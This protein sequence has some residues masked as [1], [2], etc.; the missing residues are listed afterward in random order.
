MALGAGMNVNASSDTAEDNWLV[1]EDAPEQATA[2]VRGNPWRILIVDDDKDVHLMTQF[3]LLNVV[4]MDRTL[5]LLSAYSGREAFQKLREETD[6][7]LVLLDVVMETPDAG[8]RLAKQIREEL[9]NQ[10]VRVVLRTGQPGQ[11]PEQRVIVDYDINDYKGKAELTKQKLFTT[12][13]ASLRAYD[14]LLTIERSK[15]ELLAFTAENND[16]KLALDQH[17][18]VSITD[19]M[20]KLIYAN[21]KFCNI[22]G[23]PRE[24]LIGKNHAI[25]NSHHHPRSFFSEMWQTIS[26]GNVWQ[27]E[28][29]NR[30]Q[31]GSNFWV[32]ST[33]VPFLNNEGKPYQYVAI[34]TNITERKLAE[35]A[36][37]SN[38]ARLRRMLEVSPIAV[39]IKRLSNN[40][41]VFANKCLLD[42]FDV[43]REAAQGADPIHY[44]QNPE[45]YR[46][47]SARLEQGETIVNREIGL[48]KL[49][50]SQIRVL[51]S[52]FHMEYEGEP[53]VMGWFFEITEILH[54]RELAEAA[55]RAKSSFL[56]TM[57]HEIRTPMNGIIGMSDLLIETELTAQQGEFAH[58]IRD[59]A[60]SLMAIV[61]DILDFSKI[62]A[63]K[64]AL[65]TI[66]FSL[67]NVIESSVELLAP[68]AREKGLVVIQYIAPEIPPRLM[69]DPGRLRQILINLISNAI[70]FTAHGEVQITCRLLQQNDGQYKMRFEVQDNGIGMSEDV[71]N[72][73]FQP[74]TQADGSFTRKY[75]GTG[76]GLSI[77]KRLVE[78]MNGQIG[79]DSREGSGSRFWFEL[80][81][82][83]GKAQAVTIDTSALKQRQIWLVMPPSTLRDVM[84]T[85]LQEQD[86]T[87]R[88]IDN[89]V[90]S[91]QQPDAVDLI[92]VS[93]TV[94][95]MPIAAAMAALK[96]IHPA[97]GMVLLAKPGESRPATP[98]VGAYHCL[99]QPVK[100]GQLYDTLLR[101]LTPVTASA[102]TTTPTSTP[103]PPAPP[104]AKL[105][106]LPTTSSQI[107][108]TI[109]IL[110][111]D[112]NAVN[113][114]LAKALLN[115][116][117]YRDID[118]ADNGQIAVEAVANK[119]YHLVLMDCQ[120]PLMDGFVATR[121]IRAA[122]QTGTHHV[123]IIAMTANAIQGDRE[124]CLQAGMDDYLAK[125][126][127]PKALQDMLTRWLP[128]S[129]SPSQLA[130]ETLHGAALAK[131]LNRDR[132]EEICGGDQV[133]YQGILEVFIEHT[134][135]LLDRIHQAILQ[136]NGSELKSACHE[137][138]GSASN[139]GAD[140][141]HLLAR[142]LE[143]SANLQDT[144]LALSLHAALG[145][146]LEN[147][148]DA[149]R[150]RQGGK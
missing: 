15:E 107:Q 18:S 84:Q 145:Q 63:G 92:L 123:P 11:A 76:L 10:L 8:L 88:T 144:T 7:A 126:I 71:T 118:T 62:E 150:P 72:R 29:Q 115:K 3:A 42:M 26:Q 128:E 138:A 99:Y 54:A 96:G 124:Q 86:C 142:K 74:F 122:E 121:L 36:L 22:S 14:N 114:K 127:G 80:T 47:I 125:P 48:I 81:M 41:R 110:L 87:V 93:A 117:G 30:A 45:E 28:I 112:D 68:K 64:L 133:V 120:M 147:L 89:V 102:P 100:P 103:A 146:A 60:Q 113:Q 140:Q 35:Q 149:I 39:S 129:A 83:S 97:S 2:A 131:I 73:L 12:V 137:L 85:Q 25:L 104:V 57:S 55:S 98:V 53:A 77:C 21:D 51:A 4:F 50:H 27:G 94:S 66:D 32:D 31:D 61:N 143:H 49:D 119:S 75:G 139:M 6:I 67:P 23:Y 58:I 132:I 16:L 136:H 130:K 17:A 101:A 44:Y 43:S 24:E 40:Q 9:N 141:L 135:S 82:S 19:Q 65:E 105:A 108:T 116:L 109:P 1:D 46:E 5:E 95:D 79:V 148:R 59:C 111:V 13:I 69:G 34:D 91:L 90:T 70:K 38:A 78:L 52:Y 20:G 134:P 106:A 56:S 37:E 33:I